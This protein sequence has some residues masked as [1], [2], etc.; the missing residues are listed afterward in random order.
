M[1]NCISKITTFLNW[2][3][4]RCVVQS[5]TK[6]CY[7]S[8]MWM[9]ALEHLFSCMLC[10]L[11]SNSFQIYGDLLGCFD[12]VAAIKMDI[13]LL[14][15][16]EDCWTG[17]KVNYYFIEVMLILPLFQIIGHFSFSKYIGKT[18]YLDYS[19]ANSCTEFP[20]GKRGTADKCLPC[21][22]VVHDLTDLFP[23]ESYHL[24]VKWQLNSNSYKILHPQNPI[25]CGPVIRSWQWTWWS[26]QTTWEIFLG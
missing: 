7:I 6:L 22:C 23:L 8:N 5:F 20:S 26:D 4:E 18:M 25:I 9:G 16:S 19:A 24:E 1:F 10:L 12:F 14:Y 21:P 13:Q 17:T 2:T 3:V 15:Y 11:V